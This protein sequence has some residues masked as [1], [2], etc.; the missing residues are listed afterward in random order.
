[1][2]D[3]NH[4]PE[5]HPASDTGLAP[6]APGHIHDWALVQLVEF[7]NAGFEQFVTLTVGG[8]HINGKLITGRRF[9]ERLIESLESA[10]DGIQIHPESNFA[11]V[12]DI[13][14]ENRDIYPSP[15]DEPDALPVP[16]YIHLEDARWHTTDGRVLPGN[17]M[18][19]RGKISA[20]DGFSIGQFERQDA[21]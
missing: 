4:N 13:Y 21:D 17:G 11:A 14:R 8:S 1:M 9:Y 18:I 3:K 12:L 20:V 2:S 16:Y 10:A 7:A 15:D 5:T 19:W 6:E